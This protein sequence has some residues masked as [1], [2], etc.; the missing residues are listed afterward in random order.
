MA[1][2]HQAGVRASLAFPPWSRGAR[3]RGR[4]AVGAERSR[5]AGAA[6]S[7]RAAATAKP[8]PGY[9]RGTG[10]RLVARVPA[11]L[12]GAVTPSGREESVGDEGRGAGQQRGGGR[13]KEFNRSLCARATL[14]VWPAVQ[15]RVPLARG[16]LVA[17]VHLSRF[18]RMCSSQIKLQ[19]HGGR[20]G[21][22]LMCSC[23]GKAW[24][25]GGQEEEQHL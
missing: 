4:T 2:Q 11:C 22:A 8:E 10:C 20:Y 12:S 13:G 7:P 16:K 1:Q 3:A 18:C 17:H 9:A 21:L 19:Q 23:S 25:C 14:G 24:F 5:G 6:R 15:L